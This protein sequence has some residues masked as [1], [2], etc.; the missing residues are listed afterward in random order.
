MKDCL[1]TSI[2]TQSQGFITVGYGLFGQNAKGGVVLYDLSPFKLLPG[3]VPTGAP[4]SALVPV[5][6]A[7][8]GH[9]CHC[10]S[11]SPGIR[12]PDAER[13]HFTL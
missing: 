2:A 12:Q 10:A 5:V 3:S 13:I 8:G 11:N 6:V 4:S 1:I 7:G 9:H